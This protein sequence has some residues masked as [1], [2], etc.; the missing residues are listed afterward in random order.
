MV[1]KSGSHR[2]QTEGDGKMRRRGERGKETLLSEVNVKRVQ[3]SG[4]SFIAGDP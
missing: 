2:S 4:P 1:S 3:Y